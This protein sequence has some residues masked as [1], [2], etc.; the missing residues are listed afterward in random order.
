MSPVTEPPFL[1]WLHRQRRA[2]ER[3]WRR[4]RPEEVLADIR[5]RALRAVPARG[6]SRR[7]PRPKPARLVRGP[8]IS[9]R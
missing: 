2:D 8:R 7:S 1:R 6:T 3:R 5:G 9:A 4:M